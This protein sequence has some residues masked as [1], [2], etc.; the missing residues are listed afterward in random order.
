MKKGNS[1]FRCPFC[2]RQVFVRYAKPKALMP[3]RSAVDCPGCSAHF[4]CVMTLE[5]GGSGKV[6]M[7]AQVIPVKVS[8]LKKIINFLRG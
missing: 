2:K 6:T 8:W 1:E 4:E 5:P 3:I 7:D